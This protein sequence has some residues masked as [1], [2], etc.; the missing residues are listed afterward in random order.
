MKNFLRKLYYLR[1][2]LAFK[3][4][5]VNIMLSAKGKFVRPNEISFGNNVFIGRGFLISA[6]QLVFG[7]NIMIGPNLVIECDD[8]VFDEVGKLMFEVRHSR[9][10]KG[11]TIEDDVWIGANVTIL[12]GVTI[13]EGAI[14]GAAS[15]VKKDLPPY[16]ICVGVPC[17][18]IKPRFEKQNLKK[19]LS[20]VN[21]KYSWDAVHKLHIKAGLKG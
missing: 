4:Y 14:V 18:A 16:S 1:S 15:L 21:S 3:E 13:G 12:G 2:F 5:G 17:R 6:R 8:H 9:N 20:L 7:N 10:V 11:V 19:H